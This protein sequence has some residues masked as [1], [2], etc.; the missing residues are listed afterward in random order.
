MN[1]I[2]DLDHVISLNPRDVGNKTFNLWRLK[3]YGLV[4]YKMWALVD[5]D[6][7]LADENIDALRSELKH[8]LQANK[9][10]SAGLAM[11]SSGVQEDGGQFSYAGIFESYLDIL[12]VDQAVASLTKICEASTA[13]RVQRYEAN[14]AEK[15]INNRSVPVLIMP[16]IR[17]VSSGVLF[18]ADPLT[19]CKKKLVLQATAGGSAKLTSGLESG[20]TFYFDVDYPLDI[21]EIA[22][23][24]VPDKA[25]R[26]SIDALLPKAALRELLDKSL[27]AA[28][29]IDIYSPYADIEWIWDGTTIHIIQIRPI[30]RM[31]FF[32]YPAIAS[33]PIIWSRA[34]LQEVLPV[35]LSPLDWSLY[36]GLV[37][38]MV[39][40]TYKIARIESLPGLRRVVAHKGKV[41]LALS[42][43]QYE[44]YRFFGTKPIEINQHLGEPGRQID[45]DVVRSST[46]LVLIRNILSIVFRGGK[47]KK[48]A[49]RLAEEI[50]SSTVKVPDDNCSIDRLQSEILSIYNRMHNSNELMFLQGASGATFVKVLEFL[51]SKK[52]P[53]PLDAAQRLC[54]SAQLSVTANMGQCIGRI[55]TYLKNNL[56]QDL[57]TLNIEKL[58][59]LFLRDSNLNHLISSFTSDHGHRGQLESY[60]TSPRF[61]DSMEQLVNLL[62]LDSREGLIFNPASIE[63]S[64][65]FL[66]ELRSRFNFVE[67]LLLR[68]LSKIAAAESVTR[69]LARSCLIKVQY[70]LRLML[71][72]LGCRGVETG[73]L[74]SKEDIF[75]LSIEEA[76]HAE[77]NENLKHLV[78]DRKPV[79]VNFLAEDSSDFPAESETATLSDQRG[80]PR[81]NQNA[82]VRYGSTLSA[83]S[84]VTGTVFVAKSL[85]DAQNLNAGMILVTRYTDPGWTTLFRSCAAVVVEV[86]G[87]LSHAAIV[88]RE[89]SLPCVSNVESATT[90]LS[91]GDVIKIDPSSGQITKL[92]G[93][94]TESGV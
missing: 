82:A 94:K 33:Q 90:W 51:K 2:V 62:K 46:P 38:R 54:R 48:A 86:G 41:H 10:E 45:I 24:C 70:E 26:E 69:E 65:D 9:L 40:S 22:R 57:A 12:C 76:A 56:S 61:N 85:E 74:N 25:N 3:R 32:T 80:Y 64:N 72:A 53:D 87:I 60:I 50:Q 28:Q 16:M 49:L 35:A 30:T 81:E 4:N 83:G 6:E 44:A 11:R 47:A 58:N 17:S 67:W 5:A 21:C 39:E 1:L 31:P 36:S 27:R 91:T 14:R 37:D 8:M 88:A 93:S 13:D 78:S 23:S 42:I 77:L 73:V 92:S 20:S 7:A 19:G 71:L 75:L 59:S 18:T 43:I 84:I 89:L 15:P 55:A 79:Y 34:N 66:K 52:V 63:P 68:L 29:A